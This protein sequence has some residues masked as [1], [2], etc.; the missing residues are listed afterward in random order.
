MKPACIFFDPCNDSWMFTLLFSK[1]V[2]QGGS[3]GGFGMVDSFLV[4]VVLKE[5]IKLTDLSGPIKNSGVLQTRSVSLV[6]QSHQEL[7]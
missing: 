4:L 6:D 5:G 2:W 1:A 3:T 7:N